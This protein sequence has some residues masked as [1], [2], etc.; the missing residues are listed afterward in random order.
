MEIFFFFQQDPEVMNAPL[1]S[2]AHQQ[3]SE[4]DTTIVRPPCSD[5]FC[6]QAPNSSDYLIPLPD[7]RNTVERL[8]NEATGVTLSETALMYAPPVVTSPPV[9]KC[10]DENG[11]C[12]ET[13]F[14]M[15][16]SH[17]GQPLL[18]TKEAQVNGLDAVP[19]HI[20]HNHFPHQ[21]Q[22]LQ[23]KPPQHNAAC[24]VTSNDGDYQPTLISLD[25]PQQTPTT[26]KPP[27]SFAQIDGITLDPS[28]LNKT[29]G[30]LQQPHQP[31]NKLSYANVQMLNSLKNG[32]Q[33]CNHQISTT[34]TQSPTPPNG[35]P[36][37]PTEKMNGNGNSNSFDGSSST[38]SASSAPFA[39]QGF[40]DRYI[41]K[42]NHSEIS[43]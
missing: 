14:T 9:T 7:A 1:P 10:R 42:E 11:G 8:L 13:S 12:W 37:S 17:S 26:I 24:Q 27:V 28:A 31:A 41:A 30:N 4:T 18:S 40:N 5:E 20:N 15:P 25:T 6:L 16:N 34:Q 29:H 43:C 38:I 39:I 32:E 21:N 2:I 22:L 36:Q 35:V 33:H 19:N 3:A 23:K